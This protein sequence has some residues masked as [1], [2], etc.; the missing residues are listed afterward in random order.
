MGF[1]SFPSSPCHFLP[2]FLPIRVETAET[3]RIL[4]G[5]C[6]YL[7]DRL[8]LIES[9]AGFAVSCSVGN[10]KKKN[11]IDGPVV[12]SPIFRLEYEYDFRISN[13]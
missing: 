7:T 11:E 4:S 10:E 6:C 2:A 13:Q 8:S 3:R 1:P 9:S 12:Q 5:F